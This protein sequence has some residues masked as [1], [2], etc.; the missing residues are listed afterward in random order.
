MISNLL[1][2]LVCVGSVL[3][4]AELLFR[5]WYRRVHGHPYFVALKFRWDENHVVAHP[6]LSFAYRK[7]GIIERNQRL[8]YA[9]APG[10]FLSFKQ[11]LKLNSIG[12]FG[13]DLP[14][15]HDA[16]AL[17]VACLGSSSLG[18]TI[19][20]EDRAYC[21]PTML[22]ELLAKAPQLQGRYGKFEIMNCGIG[23]WTMLDIFID[24]ALNVL[25]YRPDYVLIYQGLN[26]LPLH[27]MDDY[28]FDYAHG[29]RNLGEALGTIKRG[30]WFPKIAR[31]QSYEFAK[32][33]LVG[34]GNVRN[35]VLESV[36]TSEPDYTRDYRPLI[37]EENALRQ[38]I[39]LCQ[40][41]G[42]GVIISS[43]VFYDHSGTERNRKLKEGVQLENEMFRKLAG[44]HGLKFVDLAA[45]IPMRD[46][47]FVDAVHFSPLGM[48]FVARTMAMALQTQIGAGLSE[49]L[50]QS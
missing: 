24:F 8:K 14:L 10:R 46:D 9:L 16:T 7:N 38:I 12:H 2:S 42:I 13:P 23:G 43:Y 4:A 50:V 30:Y 20:D 26:D 34:T 6:F 36:E 25:N 11:P 15:A 39:L 5:A 32:E 19:A 35:E 28:S 47:Y 1:V 37:A 3:F 48:E 45:S 18:N 22:E 40:A 49:S 41:H 44:E 33:K 31:W 17:R 29:R 21:W 27:L